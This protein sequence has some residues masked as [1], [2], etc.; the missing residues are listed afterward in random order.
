MSA[1]CS[2]RQREAIVLRYYADLS[3]VQISRGDGRQPRARPRAIGGWPP[4]AWTLEEAGGWACRG[5]HDPPARA[6]R[7][8]GHGREVR[9]DAPWPQ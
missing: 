2:T 9:P 8:G 7:R 4:C 6:G 5:R 1:G 3:E